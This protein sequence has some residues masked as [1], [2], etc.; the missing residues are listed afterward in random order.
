MC[1]SEAICLALAF[2]NQKLKVLAF[3]LLEANM[4]VGIIGL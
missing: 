2:S 3:V 1:V 4:H